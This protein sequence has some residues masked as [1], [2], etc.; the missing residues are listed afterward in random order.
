LNIETIFEKILLQ[1]GQFLLNANRIEVDPDRF[2]YLVEDALA[3][4]S[5]HSPHDEHM[6][7]AMAATRVMSL[8]ADTITSITGKDYLGEP[9]W[10]SDVMPVRMHGI[11]PYHLFKNLDP[12]WNNDLVTKAQLPF[13]YRKPLLYVSI[14]AEWEVHAVWK[15]KVVET[16]TERDG[17]SYTVPT[18]DVNDVIFFRLLKGM[19]LQSIGKSRRAFTLNDLPIAMDAAEIAAEGQ[20]IVEKA[21]EDIENHQKFYLAWGG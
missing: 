12:S 2:R 18:I 11:N 5:K 6:Y 21:M 20:E 14:S 8:N 15:H 7:V 13:K 19:F 1:S 4:Y 3:I 16:E 10:I 9:D 17:F